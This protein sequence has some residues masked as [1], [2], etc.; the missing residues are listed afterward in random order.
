MYVCEILSNFKQNLTP[1][2]DANVPFKTHTLLPTFTP[3][4]IESMH[5]KIR[6]GNEN[7]IT[8]NSKSI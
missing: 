1:F 3:F 8:F 6:L 2:Y 7:E 4:A 5:A